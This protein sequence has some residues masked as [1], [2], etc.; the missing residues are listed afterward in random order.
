MGICSYFKADIHSKLL[1]Y[2]KSDYLNTTK[3]R[4]CALY[5]IF[6][7]IFTLKWEI[8]VLLQKQ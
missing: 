7:Y 8:A 3:Y 6:I 1:A 5:N 4:K 2:K